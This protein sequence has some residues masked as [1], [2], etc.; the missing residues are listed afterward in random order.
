LRVAIVHDWLVTYAGAERVLEQ[1]LLAYPEADVF[2]LVDFVD[3]DSRNWLLNKKVTTS[4]VQRLPLAKSKYRLYL[5][6]MMIAVEQFDL[7]SYDVII[8]SSHAVAKG[9][10]TGPNQIHICM[11]YSPIR[12]AWDLQHQYLA[13]SN[14]VRGVKSFFAR[15]ILHKVRIWDSRTSNGV[16]EFI[17][18]SH[19]ISKRIKKTYGRESVVIYPSVDT[20][21]FLPRSVGKKDFYVT[22]SRMVPY[23]KID[24]IVE[25]FS[26][27]FQD[28]QLVVIGDGP[29][30]TKIKNLAGSN[31]RFLGR[32]SFEVLLE[33]LA[34]AKAFIFAAEEDF[35]IAPLEA[36]SCGTPVIALGKGGALETIVGLESSSSTGVFFKEQ[37]IDS[38]TK[39]IKQFELSFDSISSANCRKNAL[40]F[41]EAR[42]QNEFKEFITLKLKLFQG[43][44]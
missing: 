15:W 31:V 29:D 13:E 32:A 18:I 27:N 9:V 5:P 10:L 39:A 40:R 6:L 4:F 23:K 11:C 21:K 35:G 14:M 3:K 2:S 7:S 24:L 25:T 22:C 33:H 16:D 26:K 28:K 42:F 1:M 8:S 43:K 12:Y 37:T 44:K 38:L 41:S 34:T 17:A 19:F 36:Q 30:Y 20:L